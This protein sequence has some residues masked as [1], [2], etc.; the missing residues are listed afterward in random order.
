MVQRLLLFVA[1]TWVRG[2]GQGWQKGQPVLCCGRT[3]GAIWREEKVEKEP[4]DL[5]L[6][7]PMTDAECICW[8][9]LAAQNKHCKGELLSLQGRRWKPWAESRTVFQQKILKIRNNF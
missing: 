5:A 8:L 9:L 3:A 4:A 7:I 2:V 1:R 6:T